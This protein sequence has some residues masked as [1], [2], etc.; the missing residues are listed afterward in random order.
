[1]NRSGRFVVVVAYLFA[2]LLFSS[3]STSWKI[4]RHLRKAETHI[5]K[6]EAL[7]AVWKR[8]TAWVAIEIPVPVVRADTVV[9]TN[10]QDTVILERERLRVQV[11]RHYDTLTVEAECK[12]DTIE[13][14]VPVV[15]EKEIEM[16]PGKRW[17]EWLIAGAFGAV[18]VL[19]VLLRLRR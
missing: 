3:C 9:I 2:A 12:A 15:V 18:L 8:D 4:T 5:R 6:A 10:P 14:E 7:G 17:H 19:I 13:V 16:P 1:M 11:V